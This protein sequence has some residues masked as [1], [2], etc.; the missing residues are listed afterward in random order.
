MS[1]P[2]IF[3]WGAYFYG[4]MTAQAT[5]RSSCA[6]LVAYFPNTTRRVLDLGCGPGVSTIILAQADHSATVVGLD[7]APRM[8]E[9]AK[10]Y[11][12]QAQPIRPIEYVLAD[13]A[14]LPFADGSWDMVTGHSFLYLVPN[15]QAVVAEAL[16]VLRHG[17]RIASMEPSS[18]Q[19]D[20]R[21]V[22]HH[23]R[24]VRYLISVL[25]WRPYSRLHG[26][27]TNPAFQELL[28]SAGFTKTTTESVL[29]GL[30]V[31]GCGEKP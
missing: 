18:S 3:D 16:R 8:L 25:L 14:S 2:W 9:Q 21:L 30:G 26:Q 13:A 6:R 11:S 29:D 15:R 27:L 24:E 17:G 19:H 7:L 5:W 10:R 22:L 20:W 31:I 28:V 1:R 4:V 12:A 23:W